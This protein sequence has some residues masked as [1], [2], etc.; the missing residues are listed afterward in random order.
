M[1]MQTEK[2]IFLKVIIVAQAD[3]V[4]SASIIDTDISKTGDSENEAV[5]KL[6][7]NHQEDVYDAVAKVV[8]IHDLMIREL[9]AD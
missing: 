2:K 9:S 8:N 4:Y 3:G 6:V 7:T 1:S 5:G